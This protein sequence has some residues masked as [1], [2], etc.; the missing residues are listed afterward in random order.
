MLEECAIGG[1]YNEDLAKELVH[2]CACAR[3]CARSRARA[4]VLVCVLGCVTGAGA[5]LHER[6]VGEMEETR[7]RRGVKWRG[8]QRGVGAAWKGGEG[9]VG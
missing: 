6:E 2:A 3:A 1:E 7:L 8:G 4:R 9:G 5:A